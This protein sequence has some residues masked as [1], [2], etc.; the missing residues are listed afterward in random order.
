MGPAQDPSL[1]DAPSGALAFSREELRSQYLSYRRRQAR[2]LLGLLSQEAVRP[3]YRRALAK[4]EKGCDD[5]PM[6]ILVTYCEAL[7]PLPPFQV[8]LDDLQAAPEA[9]W[10]DLE[11]SAETPSPSEPATV[12]LRRFARG[13]RSWT[14]RLRGFRDGDVWRGFIAFEDEAGDR[15]VHRTA[16]IFC[17]AT[18]SDLRDRFRGF[19]S[20]SLEAFLRSALP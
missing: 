9:H 3:L 6:E 16:L 8:W 13:A 20:A 12:D 10:T 17:E 15:G 14:A 4:V 2:G 11:A 1:A 5:D 18:V 19:E 7:L